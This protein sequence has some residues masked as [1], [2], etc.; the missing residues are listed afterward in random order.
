MFFLSLFL[1]PSTTSRNADQGRRERR[2]ERKEK[3]IAC[4]TLN[5]ISSVRGR[6]PIN[7]HNIHFDHKY[8]AHISSYNIFFPHYSSMPFLSA[9]SNAQECQTCVHNLFGKCECRSSSS[10][11]FSFSPH[12]TSERRHS[13]HFNLAAGVGACVPQKNLSTRMFLFVVVL[14][15]TNVIMEEKKAWFPPLLF[16]LPRKK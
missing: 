13:R 10:S 8:S 4:L 6:W 11:Y 16:L 12:T 5:G 3:V 7:S 2:E 14:Y 15:V 1:F 9:F